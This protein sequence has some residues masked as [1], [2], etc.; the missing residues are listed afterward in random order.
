[1]DG[2]EF[3]KHI[4]NDINTSHIPFIIIS[5][6]TTTE[7]KLKGYK[8][9]IDAYLFKPFNPVLL[10]ARINAVLEKKRLRDQ[11]RAYVRQIAHEKK[12]AD[13]LLHV[14]FPDLVVNELKDSHRRRCIR[15]RVSRH[16]GA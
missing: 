12:R 10:N 16:G 6:L 3:C 9:G 13:D 2:F 11:E 14:I 4:K 1:M 7:D 15:G 5:A 8:L